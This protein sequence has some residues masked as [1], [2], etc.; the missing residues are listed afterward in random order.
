MLLHCVSHA[1]GKS[2][3]WKKSRLKEDHFIEHAL[4]ALNVSVSYGKVGIIFLLDKVT[5]SGKHN[6]RVG[7]N[8]YIFWHTWSTVQFHR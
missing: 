6:G 3:H 1:R 2:I 8:V 4:G 5:M 7:R